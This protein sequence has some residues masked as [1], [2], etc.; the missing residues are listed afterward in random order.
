MKGV[1]LIKK[2]K[3]VKIILAALLCVLVFSV[4]LLAVSADESTSP[5]TDEDKSAG[6]EIIAEG[7]DGE[8]APPDHCGRHG[9]C[10]REFKSGECEIPEGFEF[11]DGDTIRGRF[12]FVLP[13]GE[14][15]EF[16][17]GEEF[18]NFKPDGKNG[19][20]GFNIGIG[21]IKGFFGSDGVDIAGIL[22][23]TDD[24]LRDMIKEADGNIFKILEDAGK[25]EEYKAAILQNFKDKLDAKVASGDIT[26]EK[27]D[28]VYEMLKEAVEDLSGEGFGAGMPGF[29]GRH[30]DFKDFKD[31]G[32]DSEPAQT[33]D[34]KFHRAENDKPM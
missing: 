2:N 28:E 5:Q 9:K 6:D 17:D 7:N 8:A 24:E 26:Q 13:D 34:Y 4:G 22:G 19:G 20:F 33:R 12:E 14:F 15:P 25:L 29:C 18:H 23:L 21:G 1:V 27:A 32:D 11:P 30:R 31:F 3:K 10:K 16:P